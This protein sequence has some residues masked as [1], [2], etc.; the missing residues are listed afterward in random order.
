MN[1][2]FE[3]VPEETISIIK[4]TYENLYFDTLRYNGQS[5]RRNLRIFSM[6]DTES[7][8]HNP[9]FFFKNRSGERIARPTLYE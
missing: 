1:I 8:F 7:A 6:C 3:T 4:V 2:L 5:R 9:I